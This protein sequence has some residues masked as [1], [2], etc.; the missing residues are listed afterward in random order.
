MLRFAPCRS[1]CAT[2]QTLWGRKCLWNVRCE[3][4]NKRDARLLIIRFFFG[5]ECGMRIDTIF[6]CKK[7]LFA[8]RHFLLN[9]NTLRPLLRLGRSPCVDPIRSPPKKT[10][11]RMSL[12]HGFSTSSN[13]NEDHT[14]LITLL[15]SKRMTSVSLNTLMD[16]GRGNLL[17]RHTSFNEEDI[18]KR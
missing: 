8:K 13:T 7:T 3:T 11:F 4:V 14:E 5:A 16:T 10:F 9:M 2:P 15:S 17:S 6:I 18:P 12:T 1:I